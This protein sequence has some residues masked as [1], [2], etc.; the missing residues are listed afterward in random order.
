M[1]RLVKEGATDYLIF[2]LPQLAGKSD[3]PNTLLNFFYL[4][5][6]NQEFFEIYAKASRNIVD[7]DDIKSIAGYI[8]NGNQIKN[9]TENLAQPIYIN[10]IDLVNL[11]EDILSKKAF[12]KL[13]D[14]TSIYEVKNALMLEVAKKLNIKFNSDYLKKILI[15]YYLGCKEGE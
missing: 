12:Y 3:N 4:K 14:K 7:I 13:V 6:K 9:R 2:R 15:K 5:I 8:I 10:V 1:E 11:F